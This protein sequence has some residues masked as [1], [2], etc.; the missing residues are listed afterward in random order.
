MKNNNTFQNLQTQRLAQMP[1]VNKKDARM[2][3]DY[4]KQDMEFDE[5]NIQVRMLDK[6]FNS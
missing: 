3:W 5:N 6:F 2:V 4:L 1:T